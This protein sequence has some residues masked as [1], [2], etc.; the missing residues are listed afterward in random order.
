MDE[1]VPIALHGPKDHPLL[2]LG[3]PESHL[4]AFRAQMLILGGSNLVRLI[5]TKATSR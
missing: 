5:Q 3:D 2:G 4:K 1:L